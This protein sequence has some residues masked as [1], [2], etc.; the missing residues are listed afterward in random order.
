M[1]VIPPPNL[2]TYC[3][4]LKSKTTWKLKQ[5]HDTM[6]QIEISEINSH[7]E[8]TDF[9]QRHQKYTLEKG[10]PLQQMM[11]GKMEFTCLWPQPLSKC[12]NQ[13]LN[14]WSEITKIKYQGYT[15]R[16]W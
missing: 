16:H 14:A 1:E 2:K 13:D 4:D 6:E 9:Q 11:L 3:R 15:S 7:L 8:P 10:Y 12:K 5:V